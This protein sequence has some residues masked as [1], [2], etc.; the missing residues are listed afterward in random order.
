MRCG[1]RSDVSN[2]GLG[3]GRLAVEYQ[4]HGLHRF[5]GE[6]LMRFNERAI[7]SEIPD[8]YRPAGVE[9]SPERS[10]YFK[11]DS[12][13]SICRRLHHHS[14]CEVSASW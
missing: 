8:S 2:S 9:S 13:S 4:A 1:R 5:D 6:C 12:R 14:G 3:H 7:W 11:P 10:E